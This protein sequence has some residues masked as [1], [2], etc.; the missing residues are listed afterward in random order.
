MADRGTSPDFKQGRTSAGTQHTIEA[1]NVEVQTLYTGTI[2]SFLL[3][4]VEGIWYSNWWCSLDSYSCRF[5][6]SRSSVHSY[7]KHITE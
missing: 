2:V 7:Q 3:N 4:F 1:N 6:F 5:H